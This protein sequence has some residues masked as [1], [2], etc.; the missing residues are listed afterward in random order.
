MVGI[1]NLLSELEIDVGFAGTGNAVKE[2]GVSFDF[3]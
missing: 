2:F 3:T 1:E